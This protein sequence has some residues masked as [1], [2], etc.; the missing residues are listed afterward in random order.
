MKITTI[1]TENEHLLD[2]LYN[3]SAF[4]Y[5][6]LLDEKKE[7][8]ALVNYLRDDLGFKLPKNIEIYNARGAVVNNKFD[9][10]DR[11][12]ENVNFV[13]IP[14][15]NFGDDIGKLALVKLQLGARWFDDIVN[16]AR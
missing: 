12:N 8:E 16:N 4:T 15:K 1:T 6:G 14:L 5:V 3:D 7:Y 11:Y 13:F 9:L 2:L 10:T